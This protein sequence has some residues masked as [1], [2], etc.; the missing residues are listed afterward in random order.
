[1]TIG[2]YQEKR[3]NTIGKY[4]KHNKKTI[5]KYQ[6]LLEILA[7]KQKFLDAS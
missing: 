5:G 2:K 7:V 1:M 6:Y 4:Q 3:L